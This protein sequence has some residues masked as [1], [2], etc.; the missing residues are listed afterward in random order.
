MATWNSRATTALITALLLLLTACGG[1]GSSGGDDSSSSGADEGQAAEQ[2]A[3]YEDQDLS[4]TASFGEGGGGAAMAQIHRQ[5]LPEHIPGSPTVNVTHR[6]GGAHAVG[7][8]WFANNAAS[9]GSDALYGNSVLVR[10][11]Q[12]D[13]SAVDYDPRDYRIVGAIQFGNQIIV[14]RPEVVDRAFDP[15][16]EPPIVGDTDG[17]GARVALT[18]KAVDYAD[19]NFDF[20]VGYEGGNELTLAMEQGEVDVYGSIN[21]DDI[22]DLIDRG[23]AEPLFQSGSERA[24]DFPDTPTLEELIDERGTE[25]TGD[26]ARAY[27]SW[28]APEA[29]HHLLVVPADTPDDVVETLRTAYDEMT[30][31]EAFDEE[32]GNVMSEAWRAVDPT[33]IEELIENVAE[34]DESTDAALN[35]IY[36]RHGLPTG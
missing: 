23:I 35:E 28:L 17:T 7:N 11:F 15:S 13:P 4:I 22:N 24:P 30:Q 29:A 25:P 14:A 34:L 8:N 16:A 33:E 5:M 3:L 10:T 2:S 21:R 26:E 9:D 27:E 1:G 6:S 19:M 36:E 12:R 31:T 32:V 20:A 18:A